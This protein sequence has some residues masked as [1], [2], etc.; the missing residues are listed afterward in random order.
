M[1]DTDL[2]PWG[3]HKGKEMQDVPAS[4]LVWLLEENKC[5]GDVKLYIEDNLDV[6]RKE[7][8]K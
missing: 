2:M 5:S 4:Y 1:E 7:I 8:K 3:I 6:L